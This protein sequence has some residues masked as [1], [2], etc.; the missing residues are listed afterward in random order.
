MNTLERWHNNQIIRIMMAE[1][2][3]YEA[4]HGSG[5]RAKKAYGYIFTM[6]K[7]QT[8]QEIELLNSIERILFPGG[9]ST[10]NEKNDVEILFNAYKYKCILITNDG[11]SRRQPGGIL[12]TRDKLLSELGIQVLTDEEAVTLIRQLII[13]RDSREREE[14]HI[15]G[16]PLPEWLGSD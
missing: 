16:Q 13:E 3:Q 2:A 6:T 9:A 8:P 5:N 10:Q 1:P 15:T 11:G 7:S 14:S 4:A 12:G